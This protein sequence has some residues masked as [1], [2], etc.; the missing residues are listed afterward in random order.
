MYPARVLIVIPIW[1][2]SSRQQSWSCRCRVNSNYGLILSASSLTFRPMLVPR[3]WNAVTAANATSAAATAYSDSSSP[4][5]SFK[6]LI[7]IVRP[8]SGVLTSKRQQHLYCR[9]DQL[10]KN[11]G[12]ILSAS[13]VIF[14]PMLV[15]NVWKAATA[16]NATSAAAT[17]YSESS[18]PVSSRKNFLIIFVAP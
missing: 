2:P 3:S 15:P 8:L 17:A 1:V 13:A 18:R 5:S 16:A 11:Y 10:S 12:L 14:R 9:C 6:N 4:V 7:N